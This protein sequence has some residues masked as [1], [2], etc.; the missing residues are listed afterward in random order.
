MLFLRG[1]LKIEGYMT[2]FFRLT[3]MPASEASPDPIIIN[4]C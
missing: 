1:V 2:I 4:P 3:R